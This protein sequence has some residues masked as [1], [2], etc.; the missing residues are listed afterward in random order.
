MVSTD[1]HAPFSLELLGGWVE[2][3]YRSER[4]D[5]E[6]LPWGSLQ[7]SGL[8]E[9][10]LVGARAGWTDMAVQ[11]RIAA[12]GAA[13]VH[14]LVQ[15]CEAPL[16]LAVAVGGVAR[17]E[18]AHAELCARVIHD[19]GGP[20]TM[21]FDRTR[22]LG[23][24]PTVSDNYIADAA[25]SVAVEL[26]AGETLNLR[27]LI[28]RQRRAT[29]PLLQG[30]WGVI[31]RDE[32]VHAAVGF[33]FMQWALPMLSPVEIA[34]A[35]DAALRVVA[36]AEERDAQV[37][38]LPDSWFTSVGVFATDERAAYLA[39]LAAART[40]TTARIKAWGP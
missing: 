28:W 14:W 1:K 5:L 26:C 9:S 6:L 36:S 15:R 30:V 37:A 2:A 31:A 24:A 21:P 4:P 11:E 34:A 32:A 7:L 25:V 8:D 16:D 3:Q 23:R 18:C 29:A 19:L 12:V 13:R 17:D 35:L 40:E 33:A 10:Q 27:P 39:V 22:T 20:V 38:A